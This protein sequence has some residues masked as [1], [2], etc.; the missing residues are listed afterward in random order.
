MGDEQ[1]ALI[2]LSY[3]YIITSGNQRGGGVGVGARAVLVT[4]QRAK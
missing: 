2:L 1:T 4:L 3:C